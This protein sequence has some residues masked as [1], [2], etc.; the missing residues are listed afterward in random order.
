[1]TSAVAFA[2]SAASVTALARYVQHRT[3]MSLCIDCIMSVTIFPLRKRHA[4]C[5][6]HDAQVMRAAAV[7]LMRLMMMMHDE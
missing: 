7:R 5:T 2:V 3:H 6:S 4:S 1:M